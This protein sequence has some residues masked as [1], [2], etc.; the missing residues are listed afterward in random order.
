MAE[1]QKTSFKARVCIAAI[2]YSQTYFSQYV[3]RDYLVFSDAFHS[4]PYYVISAEKSNYLHLI[5]VSTNLSSLDFF[6]KC[7]NGTLSEDDFDISAHGQDSK[8]SK[9]SIRRKINALPS[10][11]GLIDSSNLIKEGFQK[12]SISC[13]IA[14]SDGSCTLGF[15]AVPKARPKTLLSGDELDHSKAAPMKTI[16]SK[17]RSASVFNSFLAGSPEDLV[18]HYE[19]IKPLLSDE[20]RSQV[21]ALIQ[22][23]NDPESESRTEE[24]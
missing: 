16:L 17:E 22:I 13:T 12:N 15:I 23:A 1:E 19:T 5:G 10:I 8:A 3:S 24:G 21:E 9:G 6:N 14:S 2:Q 7:F 18:L 20:L 4:Q 11:G